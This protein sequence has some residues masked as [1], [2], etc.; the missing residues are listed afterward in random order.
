MKRLVVALL[1]GGLVG[2]AGCS[3]KDSNNPL[4]PALPATPAV[5]FTM[6]ME[7]GTQGMI[8]VASPDADVKLQKVVVTYPPQ[9]FVNSIENPNPT[10]VIAK[11]SNIQI[12]EYTGIEQNQVWVLTFVGTHVATN[13]PFSIVMN[14]EVI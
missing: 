5:K 2:L 11:G 9:Q 3:K 8:F 10:Q 14:W 1:L 6:H 4:I 7:S 12:G 13:K